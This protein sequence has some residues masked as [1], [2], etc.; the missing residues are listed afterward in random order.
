MPP[1]T[2]VKDLAERKRLLVLQAELHRQIIEIERFR[3]QQ[4]FAVTRSRFQSNR[5]LLLGLLGTAGWLSTRRFGAL[6]KLVP[7][8]MTVWRMVHKFGARVP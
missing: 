8:G 1:S 6:V 2:T 5:W 7:I 3:V 4:R